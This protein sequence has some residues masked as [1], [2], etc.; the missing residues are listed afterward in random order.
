MVLAVLTSCSP[1]SSETI[2]NK[3]DLT[4]IEFNTPS[5][6]GVSGTYAWI[7]HEYT[8]NDYSVIAVYSSGY[9]EIVTSSAKIEG[10]EYVKVSSSGSLTF[11]GDEYGVHDF[12]VKVS[13]GGKS[14]STVIKAYRPGDPINFEVNKTKFFEGT[15]IPI[16]IARI[17][18]IADSGA[19]FSGSLPA[20]GVT[21]IY[22]EDAET[23]DDMLVISTL[24]EIRPLKKGDATIFY[25]VY[26]NS[27]I[28]YIDIEVI[29][30]S[31]AKS[32]KPNSLYSYVNEGD[33]FTKETFISTY[34]KNYK[35]R[36]GNAETYS[37]STATTT[38]NVTDENGNLNSGFTVEA[39]ISRK[40]E[41]GTYKE[42]T[43]GTL[44][45][46]D[47]IFIKVTYKA[48]E[49]ETVEGTLSYKI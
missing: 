41:E 21:M 25:G 28:S 18:Y 23:F 34:L 15:N 2:V 37:E 13:Y 8:T 20:K 47:N 6:F 49:K 31:E 44:Q 14:V 22:N 38:L 24:E 16:N 33:T 36:I 48:S 5:I 11:S 1:D 29:P 39:T 30:L 40:D 43:S 4:G 17:T 26:E 10:G 32:L 46:G 7:D 19:L 35:A 45:S 42:V 27:E 3:G 9:K 12:E